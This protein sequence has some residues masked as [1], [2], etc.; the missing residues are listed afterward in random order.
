MILLPHNPWLWEALLLTCAS[1][2]DYLIPD[3]MYINLSIVAQRSQNR[4]CTLYIVTNKFSIE[5]IIS[6][7]FLYIAGTLLLLAVSNLLLWEHVS[8]SPSPRL[9]TGS[10]YQ[11]VVEL[12]HY[13]HYLA[14]KVFS[15]FVSTGSSRKGQSENST[16]ETVTYYESSFKRYIFDGKILNIF[17]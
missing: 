10:L 4:L 8:S 6:F 15:D 7:S 16:N 12:S 17:H 3:F 1:T 5:W 14:S 2:L 9:S 11:R 13:T